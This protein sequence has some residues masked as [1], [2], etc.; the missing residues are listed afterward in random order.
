LADFGSKLFLSF[1]YLFIFG[2]SWQDLARAKCCTDISYH[3]EVLY[4]EKDIIVA[5]VADDQ[6][7]EKL[8]IKEAL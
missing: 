4:V 5:G 3:L 6:S 8:A 1:P 2:K 7:M